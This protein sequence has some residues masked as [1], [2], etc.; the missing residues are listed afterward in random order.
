VEIDDE[1]STTVD[2]RLTDG[3]AF[4]RKWRNGAHTRMVGTGAAYLR[5]VDDV[6]SRD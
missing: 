1:A 3:G 2:P 6:D 4:A 5:L